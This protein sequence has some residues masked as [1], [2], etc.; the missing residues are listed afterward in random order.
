MSMG[1]RLESIMVVV[2]ITFPVNGLKISLGL[3][4]AGRG[5]EVEI[6]TLWQP[7]ACP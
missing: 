1:V 4:R 6:C 5:C 2:S 3:G 7:H